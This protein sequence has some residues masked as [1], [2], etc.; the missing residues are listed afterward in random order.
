M[1][2]VVVTG[3]STGIG[4]A[5]AV[6]LARAGH[7]V[8]ATARAPG[9]A[10]ALQAAVRDES[11]PIT[12]VELDVDQ[13]ASAA[14]AFGEILGTRGH[15]DVLVNNAGISQPSAFEDLPFGDFRAMMETNFF[16]A[17]RCIKAVLP[18]MRERGSG[19]IVNVTSLAGRVAPG[20]HGAYAASKFA[21]EAVS[22]ALGQEL[23]AFGVRVAVVE[24]GIIQTAIFDKLRE[25]P[26]SLYPHEVRIRSFDPGGTGTP[27]DVV[28]R[29]IRE[30]IEGDGDQFR[31]P[32]GDDAIAMLAW[33]ASLSDEEWIDANPF[34]G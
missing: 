2:V 3:C 18:T 27:P 34:G 21:L 23:K 4:L 5:T 31:Y 10:I 15:I 11:L 9:N 22:E 13:D 6:A 1:A 32:V 7:D 12:I 30:I 19:C 20:G 14:A 28:A 26:P 16:G 24:P 8:F 25:P 29:A 33:R 17:I